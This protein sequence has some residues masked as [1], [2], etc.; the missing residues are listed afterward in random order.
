MRFDY[1]DLTVSKLWQITSNT[2]HPYADREHLDLFEYISIS[3]YTKGLVRIKYEDQFID[4]KAMTVMDTTLFY[5]IVRE[6]YNSDS[7]T[8][9]LDL[10]KNDICNYGDELVYGG[11]MI[12]TNIAAI[13][14]NSE[15]LFSYLKLR[16]LMEE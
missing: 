11:G 1:D 12:P 8:D 3:F 15:S 7:L 16:L 6:F 13:T 10:L 4:C 5:D 9:A 2:D 14:L